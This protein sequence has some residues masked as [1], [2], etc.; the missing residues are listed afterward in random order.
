MESHKIEKLL[1][2]YFEGTTSLPEE[3]ALKDY[4]NSGDVSPQFSE[5]T[6]LFTYL[7]EARKEHSQREVNLPRGKRLRVAWGAVAAVAVL[8]FGIY[9][10][11]NYREQKQAEFAYQETR[12]AFALLAENLDRGNKKIIHLNEFDESTQKIYKNN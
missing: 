8:A 1:K 5:Y 10:G 11:Q 7:V 2:A 3:Q 4:F 6:P 12:K 9:F